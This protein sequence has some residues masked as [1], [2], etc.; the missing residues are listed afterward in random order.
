MITLQMAVWWSFRL[1]GE[2][3]LKHVHLQGGSLGCGIFKRSLIVTISDLQSEKYR[4]I[5][6]ILK[7]NKQ[8]K[9]HWI[10]LSTNYLQNLQNEPSPTPKHGVIPVGSAELIDRLI[11]LVDA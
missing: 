3:G 4:K 8:P 1:L 9:P 6:E 7:N 10:V 5:L 2:A 11:G